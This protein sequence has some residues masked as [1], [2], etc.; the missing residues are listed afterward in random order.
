M[1]TNTLARVNAIFGLISGIVLLLAPVIMFIMAVGAA[2]TTE[3]A[4]VTVGTLT[5]LS[6][7]LSLV[8]IAVLV[9]GIVAIVYYKDDERVTN[10]PSVLLIVG[11]AVGLIPFLGWVGGIL[12][13]IGGSLYF[14]TLKKFVIEE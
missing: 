6:I 7:I 13:I 11:G 9:L 10:A 8:K 12:T 4:D 5:G 1:K 2:A 3:D 14:G